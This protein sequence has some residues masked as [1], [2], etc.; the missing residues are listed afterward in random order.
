MQCGQRGHGHMRAR[1]KWLL[2]LFARLHSFSGTVCSLAHASRNFSH[3]DRYGD[4]SGGSGRDSRGRNT[5]DGL[6]PLDVCQLFV[7]SSS[8]HIQRSGSH[9]GFDGLCTRFGGEVRRYYPHGYRPYCKP[10]PGT[11]EWPAVNDAENPV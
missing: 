4:S 9:F 8:G 2:V 1:R 6:V 5:L 11:I 10:Q 7:E 3:S